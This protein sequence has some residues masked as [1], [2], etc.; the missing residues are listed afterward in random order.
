MNRGYTLIEVLVALAVFAILA[1]MTSSAMYYAFDTRNRVNV[2]ANQLNALQIALTLIERDIEQV[3]DRPVR[4]NDMQ[5]FAAFTGLPYYLEFTRGGVTNPSGMEARSTLV[6]IAYICRDGKLIR[7]SW[8]VIDMPNRQ[9]Y[10]DKIL[11]NHLN[12]CTLAYL[13]ANKQ[14]FE[15][16]GED[17]ASQNQNKKDLPIAVQFNLTVQGQ[18]NMSLL[19]AIPGALYAS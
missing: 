14:V 5:L 4:G 3:L 11:L 15:E 2:Q 9:D 19:F 12:Q 8:E 18:G 1:A 10:H 17:V 6:R 7:R 16:W 13:A